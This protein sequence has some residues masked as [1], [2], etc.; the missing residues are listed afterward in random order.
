MGES[1]FEGTEFG[2]RVAQSYAS[3]AGWLFAADMEQILPAHVND[4]K[5]L[6]SNVR[7]LIV[8]RKQN[9]GRTEN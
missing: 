7:Y 9:L 8:E 1:G 5:N 2:K 4:S 3:G 6:M